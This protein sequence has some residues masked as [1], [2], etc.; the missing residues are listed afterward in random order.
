MKLYHVSALALVGWYL[1]VPPQTRFRWIGQPRYDDGAPLGSW[2][3]EQSFDKAEAC[4]AAR[5]APQNQ[6]EDPAAGMDHA[7]CVATDDPRLR[8]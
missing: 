1:M 5:L 6:G 7:V 3:T 4:N 8:S 2:T